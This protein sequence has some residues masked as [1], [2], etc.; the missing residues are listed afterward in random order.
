MKHFKGNIHNIET[1]GTFDGPGIRYVLFLQRCPFRCQ[2]CHNRDSWSTKDNNLMTAEEVLDDY[3]QY[4]SVYINGGLTIS[5]G[6]PLMQPGFLLELVKLFK[7]EGIHITLDTSSGCFN[8][9]NETIIKE[10]LSYIDLVLLD[11]KHV[12]D[13]EHHKLTKRSNESVYDFL[14][15][16]N[17]IKKDTIIR[18]VLIPSINDQLETIYRLKAS[19]LPYDCINRV[20]VL[21][22]HD[23]GKHKWEKLG[24]IYPL[25]HLSPMDQKQAKE[26]EA[27][28]NSHLD[29]NT[30]NV[31]KEK[32]K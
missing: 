27:I 5:G 6:E 1:F 17:S 28:L 7:A 4:E 15:L 31:Y 11:I 9:K 19:L 30:H 3:K 20:E 2:F 22:Y 14:S 23:H 26:A 29:I 21:P 25:N 24:L 32:T 16:L 18:H 13:Q 12:D 10:I 8:E